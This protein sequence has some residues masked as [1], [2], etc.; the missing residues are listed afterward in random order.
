MLAEQHIANRHL[1]DIYDPKVENAGL[2][3]KRYV[4][5]CP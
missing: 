5:H 3:S 1:S 4:T 2:G